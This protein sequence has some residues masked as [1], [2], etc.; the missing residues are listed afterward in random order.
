MRALEFDTEF[1]H[2]RLSADGV[3]AKARGAVDC[4]TP[5]PGHRVDWCI[6][7]AL[8]FTVEGGTEFGIFFEVEPKDGWSSRQEGGEHFASTLLEHRDGHEACIGLRDHAW[9]EQQFG[10][11]LTQGTQLPDPYRA[12]FKTSRRAAIEIE[13]SLALTKSPATDA[14]AFAP[15]LVAD[16]ALTF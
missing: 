15:C 3:E 16:R 4:P 6:V 1:A 14:E 12:T 2:V 9:L 11:T 5:T 13:I 8:C 7:D 10:L